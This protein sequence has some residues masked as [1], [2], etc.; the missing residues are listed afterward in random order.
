MFIV[1]EYAALSVMLCCMLLYFKVVSYYTEIVD[2]D[3]TA[4]YADSVD[5]DQTALFYFCISIPLNFK[6]LIG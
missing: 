1:T 2:P 3:P 6:W 5:P 4:P